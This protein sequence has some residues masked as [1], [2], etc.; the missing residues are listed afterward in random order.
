[1][2]VADQLQELRI[3][4]GNPTVREIERLIAKQGRGR[5]MAKSTIQDKISGKSSINLTQTLTIVE[6]LAEHARLTG[7]PL[8]PQET[9]Q[10]VWRERV[11]TSFKQ[12]STAVSATQSLAQ[13]PA[14]ENPWNIGAL[15]HAQMYDLIEIVES[16]Q[17]SPTDTW[18]PRVIGPMLKA[19]MSV[20][21]FMERAAQDAPQTL[22]RT[23]TELHRIFPPPE[24]DPWNTTGSP[25]AV[26]HNNLTVGAL[27]KHA[28]NY[29]GAAH[30]PA[31]VV[32]MRRAEIGE[33]VE[34]YLKAVSVIQS[35]VGIH[36]ALVLLRAASLDG[37]ASSL[38]RFVGTERQ[39][40]E[41]VQIA[42]RFHKNGHRSD[43]DQILRAMSSDSAYGVKSALDELSG[44]PLEQE[45]K[46]EVLRGIPYGKYEEYA[47]VLIEA[48]D[49][50]AA[51]TVQEAANAL[52]F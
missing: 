28:A 41:A 3:R 6:A 45:F 27:L 1:M 10:G 22:V 14:P 19:K 37:D 48:G 38:L 4:A 21:S 12:A 25:W 52:P 46:P 32:G 13:N 42:E 26:T 18:L 35:G 50:G 51:E 8:P 17:H 20:S 11:T 23:I 5:T 39:T 47:Q 9:D 16:A 43:R 49:P 30:T 36:Q 31:L 15:I 7:A 33:L 44:H 29:H 2:S 40:D 34:V 24:N